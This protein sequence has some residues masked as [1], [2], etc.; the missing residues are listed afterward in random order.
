MRIYFTAILP[1]AKY[2]NTTTDHIR[3]EALKVFSDPVLSRLR[4]TVQTWR[5]KV[6][7]SQRNNMSVAVKSDNLIVGF[8][9]D[10]DIWNWLEA[11]F[12]RYSV[13]WPDFQPKTTPGRYDSGSGGGSQRPAYISDQYRQTE[14]RGWWNMIR[15]DME[16]TIDFLAERVMSEAMK[17]GGWD[18]WSINS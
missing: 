11:G 3:K 6:T 10:D 9:V 8:W 15:E 4:R 2:P 17:R 13:M 18:Q 16:P 5:H 12:K 7:I 14:G 1:K